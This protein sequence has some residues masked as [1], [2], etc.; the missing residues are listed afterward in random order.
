MPLFLGMVGAFNLVAFWP[1]GLLLD[2][3]GLQRF[4]WP[5]DNLMLLG[6]VFNM[7]ITVVSYVVS[8]NK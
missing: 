6:V 8:T 3:A 2:C 5:H 1:I 7:C 4:E